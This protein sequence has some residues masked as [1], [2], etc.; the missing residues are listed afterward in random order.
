MFTAE[1]SA[2]VPQKNEHRWTVRPQRP[3]NYFPS[4][5]IGKS[6]L[7]QLGAKRLFHYVSI[8]STASLAVKPR[9]Q[10][11]FQAISSNAATRA[12][13]WSRIAR[14]IFPA[15][16]ACR[17]RQSRFFKWSERIAPRMCEPGGRITSNG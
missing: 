10:P 4:V 13:T 2:V 1:N 15:L 6:D 5:A 8:F 7:R 3:E 17:W 14:G 12:R 9:S 11:F 16:W